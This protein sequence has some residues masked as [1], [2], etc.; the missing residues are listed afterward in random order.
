MSAIRIPF[1]KVAGNPSHRQGVVLLQN[2]RRRRRKRRNPGYQSIAKRYFTNATG[3]AMGAV[4]TPLIPYLA[5]KVSDSPGSALVIGIAHSFVSVAF[6]RG[7]LAPYQPAYTACTL[8]PW[9]QMAFWKSG[10]V[11]LEDASLPYKAAGPPR[12][13]STG[14]ET[15][16]PD[17]GAE[18]LD[19]LGLFRRSRQ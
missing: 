2:V 6:M 17:V 18:I 5:W 15:T 10:L 16:T 9:I 13:L 14:A 4:A 1:P 7:G 3:A 8:Y 11:S 19:P 12:V